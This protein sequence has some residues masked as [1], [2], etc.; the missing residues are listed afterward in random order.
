MKVFVTRAITCFM[1]GALCMLQYQ[2]WY[3]Q[4]GVQDMWHMKRI[5]AVADIQNAHIIERNTLVQAD[6]ADL[7]KGDEAVEERSRTTMGMIRDGEHFY[8]IIG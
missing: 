3:G 1:L 2:L 6:V 7:R 8:Q 5:I 4:G